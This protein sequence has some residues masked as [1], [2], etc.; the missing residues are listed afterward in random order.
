M[1]LEPG[2]VALVTGASSGIGRATAL[3]LARR[4]VAVGLIA[5][6]GDLLEEVA[7]EV[8]GR[9]AQA[10]VGVADVSRRDSLAQAIERCSRELGPV[11]LLVANAGISESTGHDPVDVEVVEYVHRVNFLGT[12]YSVSE[13]LPSM[14]ARERGWILGVS[15]LTAFRGLPSTGAYSASKAAMSNFLESLRLDLRGTG[16]GVTVA[17]PGYVR[18]PL[19]DRSRH[20][21]PF[22]MEADRAVGRMLRAVE[23]GRGDVTFPGPLSWLV[24]LAQIIPIGLYDAL[25][26]GVRR[27]KVPGEEASRLRGPGG[28]DHPS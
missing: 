3:E 9:G 4:G 8:R 19:T 22:I 20:P 13:V 17:H 5:R 25:A 18:T 14:L 26:S 11:D 23:R 21:R 27:E 15:S 16:V 28:S 24:Q 1:R 12:V 6:R 10:A 2:H 7:A